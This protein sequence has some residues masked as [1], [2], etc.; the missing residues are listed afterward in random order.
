MQEQKIILGGD[1]FKKAEP[2]DFRGDIDTGE[3][4]INTQEELCKQPNDIL[5]PLILYIDKTHVNNHGVEAIS[6]TLGK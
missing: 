5:C 3:W 6:F 4:F 1:L 2:V